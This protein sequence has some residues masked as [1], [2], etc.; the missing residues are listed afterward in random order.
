[1]A[2]PTRLQIEATTTLP[3]Y[4]VEVFDE[5]YSIWITIDED[6]VV[7]IEGVVQTGSEQNGLAFGTSVSVEG[8]I[9]L[10]KTTIMPG[11]SFS[12]INRAAEDK[13]WRRKKIKVSYGFSTSSYVTHFVGIIKDI[14][15]DRYNVTYNLGAIDLYLNNVKIYTPVYHRRLIATATTIASQE[16]P[17]LGGY[18]AGLM[19]ELFWRA[20]GRPYAQKN[21]NY[22]E[23]DADWKFW[24]ECDSSISTPD[25]S[26]IGGENLIDELYTLAR[27]AGG[28]IYQ[29]SEGVLKYVQPLRLALSS[30]GYTFDGSDYAEYNK[31]YPNEVEV[32][33]IKATVTPRAL[34]PEQEVYSDQTAV[35]IQ[36]SSSK[37]VEYEPTLPVYQYATNP[38]EV[39][40]CKMNGIS[41]AVTVVSGEYYGTRVKVTYVNALTEPIIIQSIKITGRPVIAQ[42][43]RQLS[44]GTAQPERTLENNTYIQSYGSGMRLVRLVYDF[45][46][47]VLPQVTL[48]NMYFDPDRFVGEIVY[49]DSDDHLKYSGG[50][51]V[52]DNTAEYRIMSIRHYLAGS[53]MDITLTAVDNIP[54]QDDVFII[55]TTYSNSD[56][57]LISY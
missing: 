53:R 36:A 39:K 6:D 20:G 15:V 17:D 45:Y 55:G 21:L 50:V 46:S 29:T 30:T 11:A 32:G 14:Q 3:K 5:D 9:I 19:N 40:A 48:S 13:Y 7:N 37:T 51:F 33:T 54:T 16:N 49:I 4:K 28:Q 10:S 24:Y 1:M 34:G 8:N 57:R 23:S 52:R 31:T 41:T 18:Y 35:L 26:W 22:F 56:I 27:A 12:G 25:W 47:A 43:D 44:Y 42:E 38:L 2:N